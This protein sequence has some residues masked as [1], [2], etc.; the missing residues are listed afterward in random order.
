MTQTTKMGWVKTFVVSSFISWSLNLLPDG[1][2]GK[3]ELA[4]ASLKFHTEIL[5]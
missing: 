1:F 3:K 2:A 5:K 4:L